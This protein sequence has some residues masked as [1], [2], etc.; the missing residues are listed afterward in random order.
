MLAIVLDSDP[1]ISNR[2][3]TSVANFTLYGEQEMTDSS[4]CLEAVVTPGDTKYVY[5]SLYCQPAVG[6][7]P[8]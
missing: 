3:S 8:Q 6:G 2:E 5:P 7:D 4:Q 1:L